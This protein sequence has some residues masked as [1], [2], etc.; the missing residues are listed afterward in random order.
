MNTPQAV[1]E[2]EVAQTA[3]V[4]YEACAHLLKP[5]VK[6]AL[7][8]GLKYQDIDALLRQLM[9]DEASNTWKAQTGKPPS[10]SQLSVTTGINRKEI[11]KRLE[12]PPPPVVL[13]SSLARSVAAQ[14]FTGW[15]QRATDEPSL[16][17][18]PVLSPDSQVVSFASMA[19][20]TVR[21]VH[22]R[23]VLD[24]LVRLGLVIEQDGY[25]DLTASAFVPE[26]A[27]AERLLLMADNCCA[28]LDAALANV[29][30]D[31][32]P[33]LEQ[34]IWG[35]GITQLDCETLQSAARAEWVRTQRV[36]Y[37]KIEQVPEAATGES[38]HRIRIGMYVHHELMRE[39]DT[40]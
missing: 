11:R 24:E 21:D 39:G 13:P 23:S 8:Q 10:G 31:G 2:E 15:L 7:S 27:D 14:V 30:G 32:S 36:L 18:V 6:L 17:R 12:A 29:T 28:H 3:N 40:Q 19:L 16:R 5:L 25:V 35:E 34:A 20:A 33:F 1:A 9:L 37:Q 4:S 26:A 38:R 22:F